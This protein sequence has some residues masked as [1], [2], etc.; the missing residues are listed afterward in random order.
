MFNILGS[1]IDIP[2][3][4]GNR[5]LPSRVLQPAGETPPLHSVD[6]MPSAFPYETGISD[7]IFESAK[8][9]KSCFLILYI[10]LLQLIQKYPKSSSIILRTTS[11]IKPSFMVN[12]VIFPSL[13]RLNPLEAVPTHKF[14][15]ASSYSERI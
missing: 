5:S 2:F 7:L 3:M 4:V 11:L 6:S 9:N 14:P 1:M 13:I 10:P 15:A 12:C 8:S